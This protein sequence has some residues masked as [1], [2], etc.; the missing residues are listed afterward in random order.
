MPNSAELMAFYPTDFYAYQ[1][2]SVKHR[3]VLA[4][5]KR[6]LFPSMHVMDPKFDK[7]GC[8]LDSGCGTGWALLKFKEQGWECIGVE[9]GASA[10]KFGVDH[11]GLDIRVGTVNSVPLPN[12]HFDYIRS[13][14]SLEHDP[15]PGDTIAMFRKLIK[16]DGRLLIG[17][18]NIDSIPARF[19]GRY[20]W[21]LGAPVHTFNFSL[22]HLKRLLERHGFEVERVRYAANFG[23]V[24]GSLQIFLNRN[25]PTLVSTDGMLMNSNVAKL[26]GQAVSVVLNILRQGD[27]IEVVARPTAGQSQG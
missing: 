23:G 19:F 14:H 16:P 22:P 17:V 12:A 9:P 2:L 1:D 5:L 27:C 13:N 6:W 24:T 3:G 10:V 4:K 20:W 8:V 18:P 26:I 21:Y 7:P 25:D 11:Y 15:I